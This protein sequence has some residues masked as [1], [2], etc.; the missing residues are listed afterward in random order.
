MQVFRSSI[1]MLYRQKRG[2]SLQ[3]CQ[4]RPL[5]CHCRDCSQVLPYM[6]H[7][8][9]NYKGDG[10]MYLRCPL[11]FVSTK[12]TVVVTNSPLPVLPFCGFLFPRIKLQLKGHNFLHVIPKSQFQC[13]TSSSGRN[14]GCIAVTQKG[15]TVTRDWDKQAH[16][17]YLLCPETFGYTFIQVTNQANL[18]VKPYVCVCKIPD[19]NCGRATGYPDWCF[20]WI[21]STTTRW[22]L[23][24]GALNMLHPPFILL[25][26]LFSAHLLT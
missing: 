20:S 12:N 7:V 13:G 21:S 25:N 10:N 11:H 4:L 19:P 23:T 15:T 17:F 2:G 9:A 8:P 18:S 1:Y 5:K 6:W 3:N 24:L 26:I 14:A 16:V 22:N